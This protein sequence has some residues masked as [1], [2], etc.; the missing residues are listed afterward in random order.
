MN[1]REKGQITAAATVD[2]SRLSDAELL[3]RFAAQRDEAAF[4]QLVRRYG[5]LVLGVC[6]RVLRQEADAEDAFQATFLVLARKAASVSRPQA[7]GSWLY[8][9]AYRTALRARMLQVQHPQRSLS[10]AAQ[11]SSSS[12]A[13]TD[14]RGVLLDEEIHRLPEKY[15]L[16][17]L[18]CYLQG[19]SQEEAARHLNCPV[20]TLKVRLWR[21]RQLLRRRLQRRGLAL[22]VLF[23]AM[24]AGRGEVP[25]SLEQQVDQLVRAARGGS[26]RTAIPS[27]VV[28]QL[29]ESTLQRLVRPRLQL[30]LALLVSVGL[31]GC[32]DRL[33][34]RACAAALSPRPPA[35][36][37]APPLPQQSPSPI[38]QRLDPW[39]TSQPETLLCQSSASHRPGD[40]P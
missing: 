16:P 26:W 40:R 15:R 38:P 31:L 14:E 35:S 37:A 17:V 29:A 20:G 12:P 25:A 32:A 2:L 11:R 33:H 27:P 24:H 36:P 18:L 22:S 19:E 30:A 4:A 3:Q 8:R 9:V 6:R 1:P 34:Q 10:P 28:R 13:D 39:L 23:L 5:R 21:A 7:L